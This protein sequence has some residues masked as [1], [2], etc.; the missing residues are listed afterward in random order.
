MNKRSIGFNTYVIKMDWF[1]RSNKWKGKAINLKIVHSNWNIHKQW[2]IYD[3]AELF[4]NNQ[5]ILGC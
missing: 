1:S 2:D 3:I 4:I 5:I